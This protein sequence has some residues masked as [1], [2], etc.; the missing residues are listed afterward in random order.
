MKML[1]YPVPDF[2]TIS[3]NSYTKENLSKVYNEYNI[4]CKKLTSNVRN[5]LYYYY[6]DINIEENIY[7]SDIYEENNL[8]YCNLDCGPILKKLNITKENFLKNYSLYSS[9]QTY[10]GKI[11]SV[12]SIELIKDEDFLSDELKR[13]KKIENIK[14]FIDDIIKD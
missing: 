10:N 4:K 5:I 1:L 3:G 12:F 13:F 8:F 6:L 11:I 9:K 2:K 14:S 7:L